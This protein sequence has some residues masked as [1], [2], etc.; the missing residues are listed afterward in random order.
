LTDKN[1][2]SILNILPT[3]YQD[4][5]VPLFSLSFSLRSW[6]L[7]G[8]K[9]LIASMAAAQGCINSAARS[10]IPAVGSRKTANSPQQQFAPVF[11]PQFR[12]YGG[13]PR[14]SRRHLRHK[15][16]NA[17]ALLVLPAAHLGDNFRLSAF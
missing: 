9:I 6:R 7:C 17:A 1:I 10:P 12:H 11:P 3:I 2:Y 14:P 13:A 4:S 5:A 15:I 8:S 16:R